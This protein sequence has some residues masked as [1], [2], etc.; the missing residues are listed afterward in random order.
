MARRILRARPE[1]PKEIITTQ[2]ALSS[3]PA[4]HIRHCA[5]CCAGQIETENSYIVVTARKCEHRERAV[6]NIYRFGAS[7]NEGP[8]ALVPKFASPC[9]RL[10]GVRLN[11]TYGKGARPPIASIPFTYVKNLASADFSRSHETSATRRECPSRHVFRNPE[12][13]CQSQRPDP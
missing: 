6:A 9:T 7:A 3:C 4:R 12:M 13:R 10:K 1:A 5:A 11:T 8:T 2:F